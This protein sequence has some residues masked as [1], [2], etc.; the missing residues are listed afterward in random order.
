M[1]EVNK[2]AF[3]LW[4][5]WYALFSHTQLSLSNSVLNGYILYASLVTT[6]Q[7]LDYLTRCLRVTQPTVA[8]HMK[9]EVRKLAVEGLLL[10]FGA[11]F[12]SDQWCGLITL[13]NRTSKNR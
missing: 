13:L 7:A 4:Y 2:E 10:I 11:C 12:V 5:L 6:G 3:P 8:A 1:W 9:T